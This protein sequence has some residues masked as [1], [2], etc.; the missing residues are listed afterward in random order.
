MLDQFENLNKGSKIANKGADMMTKLVLA[1]TSAN[2]N[3]VPKDATDTA[4]G[5]WM[6]SNHAFLAAA[7]WDIDG[8]SMVDTKGVDLADASK[9]YRARSTKLGKK[10][11]NN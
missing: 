2:F 5:E 11:S 6:D 1:Q 9:H 4:L 10:K 3:P 7:P 8:V